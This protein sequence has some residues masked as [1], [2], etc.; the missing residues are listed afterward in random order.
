[1][2]DLGLG[3]GRIEEYLG[4]LMNAVNKAFAERSSRATAMVAAVDPPAPAEE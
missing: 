2:R 3:E 4:M 1:V